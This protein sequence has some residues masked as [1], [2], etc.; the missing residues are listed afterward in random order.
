MKKL[1]ITGATGFLGKYLI[2]EIVS[3]YEE[4]YVL[5]RNTDQNPFSEYKNIKLIKGDITSPE[6]IPSQFDKDHIRNN[7]TH[8]IHAA[9]FYDLKADHETC[10]L[11]NVLGTQNIFHFLRSIKNLTNF[12]YIST[13]A[14]FSDSKYFCEENILPARNSFHDHYSKTKYF[15]EKFVRENAHKINAKIT[16]VRPGIIIGNSVTGE[17][18]KL[19]GPYY[20]IN[21]FKQYH[22]YLKGLKFALLSFNPRTR[23]P[24]IPVDHCAHY[25]KLLIERDEQLKTLNTVHLV[26]DEIPT[27]EEFLK[28]LNRIFDLNIKYISVPRNV[29]HN[30]LLKAV[31]IPNEVIPF[32]FSKSSYDKTETLKILPEIANS[33]YSD[34]KEVIIKK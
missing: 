15:A 34:Y 26:S 9:A 7:V 23:I 31:G 12:T 1:F 2:K 5:T 3:L 20:F 11:Q 33:R 22:Q 28:D 19:D 10:Y 8:V 6:L 16:I 17:M 29:I 27:V 25:I 32:M 13:I 14:V 30:T 4:I 18:E 21:A 24:I